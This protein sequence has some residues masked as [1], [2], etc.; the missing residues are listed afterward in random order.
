MFFVF[1]SSQDT[2][3]IPAMDMV[4]PT[5]PTGDITDHTATGIKHWRLQD[6]L[7]LVDDST[8]NATCLLY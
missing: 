6:S 7:Y 1:Y 8:L 3:T 5:D 2:H 4:I